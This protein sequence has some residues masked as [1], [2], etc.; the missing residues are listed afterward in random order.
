M[1]YIKQ[2]LIILAISFAGELLNHWVPL[3]IPASIYGL[4]IL[5]VCLQTGIIKL[6][7]IREAGKFFIEIMSVMFIPAAVGLMTFWDTLRANLAAYLVIIFLVTCAVMAVSGLVTQAVLRRGG[8]KE[9][10]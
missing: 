3:P 6:E 5:F 2:F 1:R 9:G 8:K 4:V 10:Q 7:Q